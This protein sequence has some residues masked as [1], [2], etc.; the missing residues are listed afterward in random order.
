MELFL[1][2]VSQGAQTVNVQ[3]HLEWNVPFAAGTLQAVGYVNGQPVMTN[4][5]V[6]TGAPAGISLQP[7]RSTILADGQRR[8]AR[9]GFCC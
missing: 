4:T 2:G 3:S 6:T 5:E 7:D 8:F 9:N 1:N